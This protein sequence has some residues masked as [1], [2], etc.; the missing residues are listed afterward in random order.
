MIRGL[1]SLAFCVVERVTAHEGYKSRVS[2]RVGSMTSS[3]LDLSVTTGLGIILK[4]QYQKL[5][6]MEGAHELY[7]IQHLEV[8]HSH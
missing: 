8:K 1:D 2:S 5:I 7:H 6:L 3:I 4:L